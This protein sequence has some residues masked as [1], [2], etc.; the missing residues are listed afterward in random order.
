MRPRFG[1]GRLGL[2]R[3]LLLASGL[4]L[5]V[6]GG[7]LLAALTAH[8]AARFGADIEQRAKSELDV[9]EPLVAD[10]AVIGD[11]SLL[12]RLIDARIRDPNI[13]AV[14]W[15]D[16]HGATVGSVDTQRVTVAPAWFAAAAAVPAPVV[17][18]DLVIG[19]ATY[20][21]ITVRLT[22]APTLDHLWNGFKTGAMILAGVL[23]GNLLLIL[24][25]LSAG[26]RPLAALNVGTRR[27]GAGDFSVRLTPEGPPEMRE[28]A[29]VFNAAAGTIQQM[30]ASLREQQR[31]LECARDELE[32]RVAQRTGE[33]E[34]AN[35]DL[36]AEMAERL[37]L[38]R[39]LTESEER[40]RM[41]TELSSDWYWE[42]D[43]QLRFVQITS[44]AHN[45]GGIP[46]E[47]HVGKTRWELPHT[48]IVGEDWGAHKAALAARE[49]FHDL[50]LERD[51]PGGIRYVSVT[52]G[53]RYDA[54]GNFVGY[55]GVAKD[56][57][58]VKRGERELVRAKE[59]AEAAARAK[60]VFLANM[61][62]EI[63]T[64]MNGLLGTAA[65]LIE[66]ALDAR[67][68][69][70]AGMLHRS[71]VALLD[72]ING[73]LDFSKIEAGKLGLEAVDFDP[74]VLLDETLQTFAGNAHAKGLE[75]VC[76]VERAVPARMRGD[77]ARIRQVLFNLVGNAIKFTAH[78]HVAVE[79][80]AGDLDGRGLQVFFVVRDTG[81]GIEAPALNRIFAPF[82]QA[83]ESTTREFGGTG[84]GLTISRQLARLMGGDVDVESRPGRGS[85]FTFRVR[86]PV[87]VAASPADGMD[88]ALLRGRRV[89]VV[90]DNDTVRESYVCRLTEAG[91]V[92]TGTAD[93]AQALRLLAGPGPSFDLAVVD[94]CIGTDCGVELT[95]RIRRSRAPDPPRV[96]LLDSLG[97]DATRR[98][99]HNDGIAVRL[100]KPVRPAVLVGACVR[101]LGT[102]E[103]AAPET[104]PANAHE[105]LR[106]AG[107]VLL[108]EDN[109]V[110]QLVASAVLEGLGLR[111][112]LARTGR[113]AIDA[114]GRRDYDIVLMDCQMP[115]MDGLE[116]TRA[117][118]AAEA[119]GTRHPIIALTAHAMLGD[120]E[121]CL[122]AGMDDYLS[123]P[124]VREQLIE[125]L[126][127]WLPVQPRGCDPSDVSPPALKEP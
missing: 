111:V 21:R 60:S 44:G 4:V 93:A 28:T 36:R 117:I 118:R 80:W 101:A 29:Q 78:G 92:A 73:I 20:G 74:R 62:H 95:E 125:V 90:D 16:R 8:D 31:A 33:L 35:A 24:A 119:T 26:L 40:F 69:Q 123:K 116:A 43:A 12:G 124:L 18:R 126:V 68:A 23:G 34:R 19:G 114:L 127:R 84:L 113:E 11:Y 91:A 46:R 100:T 38:L 85:C 66:T 45:F 67:Q 102:V 3:R 110:N 87:V 61:S 98:P 2:T 79:L 103:P 109:E 7:V 106:F 105:T 120:R 65:L 112:D 25:V 82:A 108:V 42:Q 76:D 49:Q 71:A 17:E 57:T 104:V 77:P 97:N 50:L 27:L 48:R 70:L 89:L 86:L 22:A 72:V 51:L 96:V 107:D 47:A 32:S 54:A 115:E 63:R 99:Q 13:M 10:R 14:T 15:V 58:H 52:G 5:A 9:I 39:D 75:L 37:A 122:R 55:R 53:P 81:I 121:R 83:D 64:P 59:E 1:V 56:V 6:G 94:A 30:H 41:L 88:G